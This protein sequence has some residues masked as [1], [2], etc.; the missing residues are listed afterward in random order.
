M[1]KLTADARLIAAAPELLDAL[2]LALAALRECSED[3]GDVPRWN[4]GGIG[5]A[6]CRRART[7]LARV[8]G[9]E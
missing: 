6:A 7:L 2:T 9:G 1:A 8:E 4:A 3:A 5:Y